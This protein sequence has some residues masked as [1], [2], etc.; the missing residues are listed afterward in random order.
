MEINSK[1]ILKESKLNFVSNKSTSI[2]DAGLNSNI[3]LPHGCKSG[4]CGSCSV[5]LIEGKIK[6]FNGDII[7]K[8]STNNNILLCQSFSYSEKI[9]I[10]YPEEVLKKIDPNTSKSEVI[11]V[12]DYN[13]EVISNKQVTP[14]VTELTISMPKKLNFRFDAGMHM[15]FINTELDITKKYSICD[16]PDS[17][18]NP[19]SHTL[20]FLIA[21]HN[22]NGLSSHLADKVFPG[23]IIN[24]KGPYNSFIFNRL[25]ESPIIALAGGTGIAPLIPILE[26]FLCKNNELYVMIVLSVRNRREILEMDVLYNM[27][28][29]YKNFSF[30]ITLTREKSF[31]GTRFLFGR[32]KK[33]L[34]KI[35][36]DLSNHNIFICGSEGFIKHALE[37]VTS[38]K[39]IQN[40]IH[41]EVFT[42]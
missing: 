24:I 10:Q 6:T 39:A 18:M 8:R 21:K 32:I 2:L 5:K 19:H 30:K 31:I 36:K 23:D 26:G 4:N 1:V 38:L 11:V 40:N 29:K 9:I 15:D 22:N 42:S 7:S 41:A 37:T 14:I 13:V 12:K 33:V 3:S 35:F 34:P 17:K 25:D 27:S 28:Q 16:E 20:R